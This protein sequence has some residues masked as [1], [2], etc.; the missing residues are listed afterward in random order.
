MDSAQP[1]RPLIQIDHLV[2]PMTDEEL[3]DYIVNV[4]NRPAAP[5]RQ[6]STD[7]A[8]ASDDAGAPSTDAG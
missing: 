4:V 8:P 1:D 3:A 6:T 2:R 7:E 5:E